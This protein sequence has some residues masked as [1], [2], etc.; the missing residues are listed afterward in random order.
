LSRERLFLK[1]PEGL[2]VFVPL[3]GAGR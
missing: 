1:P 2:F 3:A